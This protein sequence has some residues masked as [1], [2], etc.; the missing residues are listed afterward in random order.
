MD[1]IF[2]IAGIISV[3]F[4]LRTFKEMRCNATRMQTINK[5]LVR[6]TL[7]VYISVITVIY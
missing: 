1:N 5:H 2:L 4:L 3:I 6:D 7:V